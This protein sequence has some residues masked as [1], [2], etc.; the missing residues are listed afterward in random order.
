MNGTSQPTRGARRQKVAVLAGVVALGVS[1]GGRSLTTDRAVAPGALSSSTERQGAEPAAAPGDA[2]P[3][4]N[5]L[6]LGAR[7]DG[8]ADDTDAFR[9]AAGTGRPLL[10]PKP[11]RFY[12]I[13]GRIE[14][15]GSVR[16]Q[17]MPELRMEA[18]DGTDAKTLLR[19]TGYLG[20]GIVISGL[21]LNGGWDGR[22]EAGEHS[23]GVSIV[24]SRGVV[25]EDN[26][27]E[28]T[29]GDSVYLGA[30]AHANS[31]D[32]VVRR[33]T[34]A[35]PRRCAVALVAV[36]G[37]MVSDN[38]LR[39][40]NAYVAVV[41]VEPNPDDL[42][43]VEDVQVDGNVVEAPLATFVNLYSFPPAKGYTRTVRGVTVEQNKIHARVGVEK[44]PDTGSFDQLRILRNE[45]FPAD[46][47]SVF[48]RIRHASGNGAATTDVV[49]EGNV[50]H[51]TFPSAPTGCGASPPGVSSQ[52]GQVTGLVVRG[53][54]AGRFV[55]SDCP[56]AEVTGGA[57]SPAQAAG[58]SVA[59]AAARPRTP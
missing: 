37:A 1:M 33:N 57:A 59:E 16:G 55:V 58:R 52:L 21:H 11:P 34:L 48:V 23:H 43:V 9:R 4:V 10:V 13:T 29:Y 25:V 35:G 50:D 44:A 3:A 12:R 32:V 40:A 19:V 5:V 18:P 15:A 54:T 22:A 36:K 2:G 7:G 30:N 46:S 47:S 17:G 56:G 31:A 14:V 41:D 8:V 6:E 27:I 24:G 28:D 26:V 38:T 42:T 39:K 45:F 49:V 53:N 51:G 20:P